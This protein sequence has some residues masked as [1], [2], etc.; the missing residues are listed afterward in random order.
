MPLVLA[1]CRL[2][3][4]G[5]LM[6]LLLLLESCLLG[7]CTA[8]IQIQHIEDR[9]L[10]LDKGKIVLTIQHETDPTTLP[11]TEETIHRFRAL[12]QNLQSLTTDEQVF[13]FE[14]YA[15]PL[16]L[17]EDQGLTADGMLQSEQISVNVCSYFG[18]EVAQGRLLEPGDFTWKE[19]EA[20]PV[21]LGSA[22]QTH[23]ALGDTF[24]AE[25][26]F[27]T[28]SFQVVGFLAA[29]SDIVR[30]NGTVLLDSCVVMPSFEP[31]TQPET[32][33][34]YDNQKIHWANR[35]SG[36]LY[37]SPEDYAR[38]SRSVYELLDTAGVGE[39]SVYTSV[40]TEPFW[41]GMPL[42][43]TA[44]VTGFLAA[45]AGF[46]ALICFGK[47]RCRF[48]HFLIGMALGFL[49]GLP[50]AWLTVPEHTNLLAWAGWVLLAAAVQLLL[51]G[52]L[53]LRQ[54]HAGK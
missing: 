27:Q 53:A 31:E 33:E 47:S 28:F 54:R 41:L 34:E 16:Y 37:I 46:G 4:F 38:V 50:A 44:G 48:S 6:T 19:G 25:Y 51:A 15:Q 18:L 14:L 1:K 42:R 43:V 13:Y 8:V 17:P 11:D 35:T 20:I 5:V 3:V 49:I 29:G 21:L 36:K 30:S 39:Y 24:Q 7:V 2:S 26:L 32:P 45:L 52:L 40:W 23:F 9:I 12:Y 10:D 22:F